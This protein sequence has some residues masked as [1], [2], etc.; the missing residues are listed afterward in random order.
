MK[1]GESI[2]S[3]DYAGIRDSEKRKILHDNAVELLHITGS[4]LNEDQ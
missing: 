1:T 3:L 4:L 2:L